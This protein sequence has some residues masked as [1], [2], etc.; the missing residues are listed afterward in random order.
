MCCAIVFCENKEKADNIS[1]KKWIKK[2]ASWWKLTLCRKSF[3]HMPIDTC[4]L[5]FLYN[6]VDLKNHSNTQNTHKIN[7][8]KQKI[9]KGH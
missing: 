2:T 3:I 9:I 6:F 7:E 4:L 1:S 8:T 5:T